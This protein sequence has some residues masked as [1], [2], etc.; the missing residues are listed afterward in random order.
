MFYD[1]LRVFLVLALFILLL[2]SLFTVESPGSVF[3]NLNHSSTRRAVVNILVSCIPAVLLLLIWVC[4]FGT[5]FWIVDVIPK[6][7]GEDR[8]LRHM[9]G[10]LCESIW[11]AFVTL[12]TVGWV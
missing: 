1:I 8:T 6:K 2:L 4:V 10:E 11:W 12:A 7:A 9:V 3:Y 5:L